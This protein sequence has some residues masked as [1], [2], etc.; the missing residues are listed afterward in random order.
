MLLCL[1][2]C[3]LPCHDVALLAVAAAVAGLLAPLPVSKLRQLGGK[4]GEEIQAKLNVST[5]GELV[6]ASGLHDAA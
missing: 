1:A 3:T 6:R 5:V 4:F 2:C